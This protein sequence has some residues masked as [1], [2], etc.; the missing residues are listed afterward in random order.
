L[1]KINL[2]ATN[3]RRDSPVGCVLRTIVDPA[4]RRALV[5]RTHPTKVSRFK[6]IPNLSIILNQIVRVGRNKRSVDRGEAPLHSN[7]GE[8]ARSHSA[9]ETRV[10]RTHPTKPVG[11]APS[12]RSLALVRRT[13]PTK[14]ATVAG[15]GHLL[16]D[17]PVLQASV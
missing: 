13:H 14:L 15:C 17:N 1:G 4:G 5:R 10:R 11:A 2:S 8:G 12:P 6:W 7:R 3:L 9:A 16:D